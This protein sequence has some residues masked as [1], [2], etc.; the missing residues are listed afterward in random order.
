MIYASDV[1]KSFAV[2]AKDN[3]ICAIIC[4][5]ELIIGLIFTY[6]GEYFNT[7]LQLME[8]IKEEKLN[9]V[10]MVQIVLRCKDSWN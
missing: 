2:F 9:L 5:K 3:W 7:Y 6:S 4:N 8:A 10:N 1:E